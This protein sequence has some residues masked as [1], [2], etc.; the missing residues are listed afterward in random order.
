M[1]P[2]PLVGGGIRKL[3]KEDDVAIIEAI[4][5]FSYRTV[6]ESIEMCVVW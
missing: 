3:T 6:G 5:A 2:P 1:P 4:N